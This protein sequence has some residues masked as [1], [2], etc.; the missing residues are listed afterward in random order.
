MILFDQP[1][2][3][4]LHLLPVAF[5]LGVRCNDDLYKVARLIGLKLF[6][7]RIILTSPPRPQSPISPLP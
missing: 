3:H 7:V 2:D 4:E 5:L 6:A 1:V